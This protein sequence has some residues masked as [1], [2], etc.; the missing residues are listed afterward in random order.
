MTISNCVPKLTRTFLLETFRTFIE[1]YHLVILFSEQDKIA[2]DIF[3]TK[4]NNYLK[5][6]IIIKVNNIISNTNINSHRDF[7]W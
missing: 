2:F 5:I 3:N 6:Y 7:I 1:L 4:K